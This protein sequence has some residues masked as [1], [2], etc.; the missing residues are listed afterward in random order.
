[1]IPKREEPASK[2]EQPP[3]VTGVTIA[4][5]DAQTHLDEIIVV[6]ALTV[7]TAATQLKAYAEFQRIGT[8]HTLIRFLLPLRLSCKASVCPASDS[9]TIWNCGD[10]L[11]HLNCNDLMSP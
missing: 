2:K 7:P 6:V 3:V 5:S 11:L 9:Q 1:M 4:L 8:F 10:P